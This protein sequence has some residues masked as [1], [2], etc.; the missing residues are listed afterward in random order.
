LSVTHARPRT[1][2][3]SRH[4]LPPNTNLLHH[5]TN[6]PL[7][8]ARG[9]GVRVYDDGGK[10]Y[11]EAVSGLGCVSLGF[12]QPRLVEA[13]AQQMQRLP[14]YHSF[15]GRAPDVALTLAEEL[16][17][18]VPV[19]DAHIFFTSSGSEAND[20][21]LKLIRYYNNARGQPRRKKIIAL[22]NAYH[23]STTAAT[24]LSGIEH[25]HDGF[26]LPIPGV[27]YV[28]CPHYY[29][30]G[31]AQES[32]T[33]FVER[34]ANELDALVRAEGPET[35]AAF[36]AEPV[37][38]VAGMI[39][40]PP[41][42]FSRMQAVL[43]RYDILFHA[44]EVY[45]GFGRTAAMFASERFDTP[46]DIMTIGKALT[47]AY[48]PLSA[49]VVSG[50]MYGPIEAA[51]DKHGAFAHGFT[52]TGHPVG[53]AVALET[54]RIYRED[55]ILERVQE[56]TSQ[57]RRGLEA[58][59]QHPIVGEGRNAGLMGAIEIVAD[60]GSK[61]PFHQPDRLGRY[62]MSRAYHHGLITRF[63]GNALTLVP[64]LVIDEADLAEVFARMKLVLDDAWAAAGR[65][66]E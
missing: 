43:R 8:I 57:F 15:A 13:A 55:M 65:E 34:C 31:R 20:T 50:E 64:P 4:Y 62:L 48:F 38:G 54:L 19:R 37:M 45:T 12:T 14:Y 6:G 18:I 41:G 10:E 40:P 30:F 53:C 59:A 61:A 51:S 39:P 32:E 36:I 17:R 7:V 44:D 49:L 9:E 2:Q 22:R 29:R 25:N 47:S 63:T 58:L 26:D 42:Y 46:P 5:R 16:A 21:A 52:Y 66:F 28:Q 11:I 27:L 3:D 23:G 33:A 56:R 1:P 60:K 35:I 24:S